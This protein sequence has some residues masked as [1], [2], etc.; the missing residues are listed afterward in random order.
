VPKGVSVEVVGGYAF[1]EFPDP[2]KKGQVLA[3]LID[4]GCPIDT[5]TSGPRRRYRVPE[6][7]A[8]ELGLIDE[9]RKAVPPKPKKPAPAVVD[10]V[11]I[12]P[13]DTSKITEPPVA[14]AKKTPAKKAPAK[15]APPVKKTTA[16][17]PT[18]T[19]LG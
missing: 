18:K 9:P 11:P 10:A 15:K 17:P 8:R 1:L 4:A 3:K 19:S 16:P 2:H 14:P 6:G 5:D 7:N 13:S 12:S